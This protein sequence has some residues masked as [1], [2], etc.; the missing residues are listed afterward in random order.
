[1]L[2]TNFYLNTQNRETLKWTRSIRIN[3]WATNV[4]L[5]LF[6]AEGLSGSLGL[7][8]ASA[9]SKG[10][11]DSSRKGVAS[12][13]ATVHL[14]PRPP[15]SP[16]VGHLGRV[17]RVRAWQPPVRMDKCVPG[18][19]VAE[20]IQPGHGE[21]THEDSHQRRSQKR[22]VVLVVQ[23]GKDWTCWSKTEWKLNQFCVTTLLVLSICTCN[24]LKMFLKSTHLLNYASELTSHNILTC[25]NQF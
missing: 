25:R 23:L 2:S 16:G 8:Q 19:R 20:A 13:E 3:K 1:M 17:P 21:K 5:G 9:Y 18:K 10:L 7:P 24:T 14:S 6:K 4:S 22:V 11:C 12:R 15:E